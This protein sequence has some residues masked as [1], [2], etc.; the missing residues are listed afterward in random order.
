M[1]EDRTTHFGYREVAEQDKARLV[2]GVFH[3]ATSR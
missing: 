1:A 2:G 3:S